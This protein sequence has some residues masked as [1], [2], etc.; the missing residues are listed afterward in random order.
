MNTQT[1][2]L[3]ALAALS[4]RP[5][6]LERPASTPAVELAL[7]A[8]A[9]LPDASLFVMWGQARLAGVPEARIWSELYYSDRWQEI[10][11]MTNSL[12]LFALVALLAALAGGRLVGAAAR[13]RPFASALLALGLAAT[14]HVLTDLPLHHDDGHPHFWPFSDWIYASPVSYWDP[15]HHGRAWSA[16]ETAL[17]LGLIVVL[18]RR[19]RHVVARGALALAALSYG[20]V[21]AYWSGAFGAGP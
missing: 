17:A 3:L 7:L 6:E 21:A 9:V 8:G 16:I 11:A 2:L 12:P 18:W 15:A 5:R 10:G 20:A 19:F 13:A 4:R 1:H 14:L